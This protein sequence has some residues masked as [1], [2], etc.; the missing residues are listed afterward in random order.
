MRNRTKEFSKQIQE[1]EFVEDRLKLLHDTYSDCK[2]VILQGPSLNDYENLREDLESRDDLVVLSIKQAYDKVSVT[3]F[4]IVNTYNFDKYNGYD[5]E[6]LDSIIFYGLSESY[7]QDQLDKIQ[8][9]PSPCDIYVMVKNPPYISYEE[10]IH[11]S[12]NF[13]LFRLL[14]KHNRTQWGTSILYE[15]AIP[16]ALLLGCKDITTIGWDLTTGVH[17]YKD[18]EVGFTPNKEEIEKTNDSIETTKELHEWFEREE[19]DFKIISDENKAYDK[20]KRIKSI[21]DIK[22]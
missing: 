11:K 20:I 8:V 7:A 14:K 22:V 18:D 12:G 15:Q 17:S 10:S 5:Y 16:M 6:S 1:L 2:A 4:H 21:N 3:D 13:D 9:K 19:I